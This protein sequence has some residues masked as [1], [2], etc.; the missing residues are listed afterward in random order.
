MDT[1]PLVTTAGSNTNN[2]MNVSIEFEANP[3]AATLNKLM[4]SVASLMLNDTSLE[5][6]A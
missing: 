5:H 3:N 1:S 4:I 6:K 2:E